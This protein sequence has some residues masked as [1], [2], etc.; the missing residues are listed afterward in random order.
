MEVASPSASPVDP[1]ALPPAPASA[2]A[3]VPHAGT[4]EDRKPKIRKRA[5]AYAISFDLITTFAFGFAFG[6]LYLVFVSNGTF[7]FFTDLQGEIGENRLFL[8]STIVFG[9]MISAM[10]GYLAAQIGRH[11]PYAHAAWAGGI[12]AFVYLVSE[13]AFLTMIPTKTV[14][15]T[16]AHMMNILA[17]PLSIP[18]YL[19]GA[20]LYTIVNP[21]SRL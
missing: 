8:A 10:A 17:M 18:T 21:E 11:R 16:F 1:A 7:V 12:L 6:F 13:Y 5:I 2:P 19:V 15:V 3:P 20:H 9:G 14:E 4:P